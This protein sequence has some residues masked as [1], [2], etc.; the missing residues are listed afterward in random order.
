MSTHTLFE[1]LVAMHIVTGSI[2]LVSFWVP[3]VGRKGGRV[4]GTYGRLF[5]MMMLAT[6]SI[7]IGIAFTTLSDPVATH[8]QL[9]DHPD[10]G[11][12][13]LIAGIFGWMMLYLATLTI[14]LAWQGWLCI[15]HRGDHRANG[16]WHI[17]LLQVAL[18]VVA[19]NCAYQGLQLRQPLMIAISFVGFATVATR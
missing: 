1:V 11:D 4:H 6:G 19:A 17:L 18:T 14:N 9:M 16:A 5:T 10:F 8:P 12:A 7:A 2:G 13:A 3:V 15:R